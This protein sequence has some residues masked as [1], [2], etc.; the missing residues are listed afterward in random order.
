[1]FMKNRQLSKEAFKAMVADGR[2]DALTEAVQ[3]FMDGGD[4]TDKGYRH[5]KIPAILNDNHN[6][7]VSMVPWSSIGGDDD[8]HQ[9]AV[10]A[11]T[12]TKNNPLIANYKR[13]FLANI[14]HDALKSIKKD[15]ALFGSVDLINGRVEGIF[16]E[17]NCRLCVSI[18]MFGSKL[19][20][21]REMAEAITHEVGHILSYFASIMD[22]VGY[23]YAIS[24]TVDRIL[25]MEENTKRVQLIEELGETIGVNFQSTDVIAEASSKGT[26]YKVLVTETAKHRRNET[27][28]VTYANHSWERL[29]DMLVTRMGGGAALATALVKKDKEQPLILRSSDYTTNGIHY[30]SQSIKIIGLVLGSAL[31]PAVFIPTMAVMASLYGN[32]NDETFQDHDTPERRLQ[33]IERG[34]LERLKAKKV[35]REEQE[36]IQEDLAIVRGLLENV[37]EKP[38]VTTLFGRI[39]SGKYMGKGKEDIQLR[40]YMDDLEELSANELFLA[41]SIMEG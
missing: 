5:S 40:N 28:S 38:D 19:W 17:I 29:S 11:P 13:K 15:K 37:K 1:M 25:G 14:D 26:L 34:I 7:S 12:L 31:S 9:I 3:E 39:M 41:K 35:S 36:A 8:Y 23:N 21:A 24:A 32:L 10:F 22:V 30:I 4:F 2:L 20:T 6:L 27:G 18:G 16:S 33:A